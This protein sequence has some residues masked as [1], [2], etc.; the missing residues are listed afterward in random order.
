MGLD[1]THDAYSGEYSSFNHFR[2]W[3]G[4]QIG[5]DLNE[6]IGYSSDTAT[7]NLAD[8]DHLLMDLFNH[9][10]CDGEL[11]PEQCKLI[12]EGLQEIINK[13]DLSS[14]IND[15][16]LSYMYDR[17]IQFRDGCLLAYSLNE[18]IKFQ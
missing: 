3:L 2:R 9:S 7:K 4:K 17:A 11:T 8:I 1:T 10:D 18:S 14:F 13:I 6:Y 16:E 5:I 15:P 12:A